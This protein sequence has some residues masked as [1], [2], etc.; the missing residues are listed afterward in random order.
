MQERCRWSKFLNNLENKGESDNF[1]QTHRL[2]NCAISDAMAQSKNEMAQVWWRNFIRE[3]SARGGSIARSGG[4]KN[5]VVA[6][7]VSPVKR[8]ASVLDC[9]SPL[10]LFHRRWLTLKRQ[11]AAAIQNL[12]EFSSGLS[13]YRPLF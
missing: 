2:K 4:F 3:K 10:P 8:R 1:N 9:G 11:R 12:P 6:E 5:I 13:E 7:N